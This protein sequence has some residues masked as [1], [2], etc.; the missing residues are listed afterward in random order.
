MSSVLELQG[1]SSIKM[2]TCWR[3]I[4]IKLSAMLQLEPAQWFVS[5]CFDP[6]CMSVVPQRWPNR[7]SF[8]GVYDGETSSPTRWLGM[9]GIAV[10]TRHH[11]PAWVSPICGTFSS[12]KLLKVFARIFMILCVLSTGPK[13]VWRVPHARCRTLCAGFG[14][15]QVC[16]VIS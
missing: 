2:T 16:E 13:T 5:R 8:Q 6:A 10:C 7:H 1:F 4:I 12:P 15:S 3:R 11:V 9:K 14:W